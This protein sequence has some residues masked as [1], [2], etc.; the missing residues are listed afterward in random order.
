MAAGLEATVP[1]SYLSMFSWQQLELVVAGSPDV[2][3][4]LLRSKTIYG[5]RLTANDPHIKWLW[6]E[7]QAFHPDD[8]LAFLQFVWGRN[9]LPNSAVEFGKDIFKIYEHSKASSS[10]DSF[11]P[12]SSTCF[13]TLKI[14][15][16][17]NRRV[18]RSKLLY[19]IRNCST[20][21]ADTTSEGRSNL[22]MAWQDE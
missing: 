12:I 14:P 5:G 21:D 22:S 11:L 19:A 15:R 13:F 20:I 18:L 17:T 4:A 3:I 9:R 10:P 7:L 2:D 8:K 16:Y 6:A 1:Y